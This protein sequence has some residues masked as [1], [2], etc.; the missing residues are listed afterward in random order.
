MEEKSRFI[1]LRA[2]EEL[3]TIRVRSQCNNDRE[4]RFDSRLVVCIQSG[5]K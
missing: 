5:S 4:C 3:R 1:K 2:N